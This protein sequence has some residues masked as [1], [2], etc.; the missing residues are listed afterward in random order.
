MLDRDK[1]TVRDSVCVRVWA[2]SFVHLPFNLASLCSS[3]TFLAVM[4]DCK[5]MSV[6]SASE[7]ALSVFS[8]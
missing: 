4:L 5:L 6:M 3:R 7:S 2:K 8:L 1:Q